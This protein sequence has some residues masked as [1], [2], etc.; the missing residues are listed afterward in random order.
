VP[1]STE[2]RELMKSTGLCVVLVAKP[3]AI[4]N[5]V[6]GRTDRP[7]LKE[8]NNPG[9]IRRLMEKRHDAYKKVGDIFVS[10]EYNSP[11][12]TAE[13]IIENIR[14]KQS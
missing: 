5:R 7:L 14:K 10:T 6:Y 2:N 4:F 11:G 1:I 8:I 13:L 3:E 12:K 9:D